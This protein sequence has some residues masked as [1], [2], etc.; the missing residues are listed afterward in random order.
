MKL[1]FLYFVRAMLMRELG[2][3]LK[4]E[5]YCLAL[6][7]CVSGMALKEA[8]SHSRRGLYA[9]LKSLRWKQM[10]RKTYEPLILYG[11]D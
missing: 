2:E 1:I 10:H 8:G 5:V 6:E 9:L 4:Q 3:D 7:A 11:L